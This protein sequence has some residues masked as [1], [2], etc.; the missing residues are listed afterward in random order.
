MTLHTLKIQRPDG[1]TYISNLEHF[2]ISTVDFVL[3]KGKKFLLIKRNEG[4]FS[5]E[6]FVAGG[7][8]ERGETQIEALKHIA[9]REVGLHENDILVVTFSHFQDVF[10]PASITSGG[11]LPEWHSIW[12]FYTI[13]VPET[14]E[15][16]LDS[17]SDEFRW[18]EDLSDITVPEPVLYA[19]TSASII[20]L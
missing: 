7:R 18:V 8:Q 10:N 1:D 3:T 19:L 5:G 11:P 2:P 9:Q 12:H 20:T 13:E 17:T 14:F 4:A 6:W 16:I 15:P